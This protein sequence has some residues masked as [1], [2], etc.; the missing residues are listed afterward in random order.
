MASKTLATRKQQHPQL[1]CI[2][3]TIGP[4][5]KHLPREWFAVPAQSYEEGFNTGERLALDMIRAM[6]SPEGARFEVLSVI[7]SAAAAIVD[8]DPHSSEP[9]TRGAGAGFL[10]TVEWFLGVAAVVVDPDTVQRTND[11]RRAEWK[12]LQAADKQARRDAFLHRM[13][14]GKAAAARRRSQ[15]SASRAGVTHG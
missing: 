13:E 4:R 14:V 6:R 3:D 1:A 5:G 8:F 12:A 10:R 9:S 7:K 11:A 15:G 2:V